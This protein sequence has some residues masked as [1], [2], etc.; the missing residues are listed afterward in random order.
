MW[1]DMEMLCMRIYMIR[2]FHFNV[3]SNGNTVYAHLHDQIL[4]F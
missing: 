4:S 1:K 2:Y 3:V